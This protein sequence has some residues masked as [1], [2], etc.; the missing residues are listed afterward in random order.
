[1]RICIFHDSDQIAM[2]HPP[3]IRTNWDENEHLFTL[4]EVIIPFINSCIISIP[5]IIFTYGCCFVEY[6]ITIFL[7]LLLDFASISTLQLISK[8]KWSVNFCS[9]FAFENYISLCQKGYWWFQFAIYI[10][11]HKVMQSAK[12]LMSISSI[13]YTFLKF[14]LHER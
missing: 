1:M 3:L 5:T 4:R 12:T 8:T 7:F 2:I 6:D 14:W 9:D 11:G 13:P 10:I